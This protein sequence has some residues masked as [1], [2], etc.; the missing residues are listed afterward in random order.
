METQKIWNRIG[1]V[2]STTVKNAFKFGGEVVGAGAGVARFAWDV[3]TAPWN[4]QD[5]YNGFI[6]PFKTAASKQGG[7]IVKPFASAGGGNYEGAWCCA[8]P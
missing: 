8:S 6:Q 2:A 3:G 5:Q 1:D 7:D 4:N